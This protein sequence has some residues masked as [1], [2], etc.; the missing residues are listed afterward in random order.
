MKKIEKQLN[1]TLKTG[2]AYLSAIIEPMKEK[3][4]K[5]WSKMK[6]FAALNLV[7]DPCFKL[8]L[9]EFT[10]MDELTPSEA[11]AT[12]EQIKSSVIQCFIKLNSCQNDEAN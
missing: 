3:Y 7:F 9:I 10:L 2:P 4:D 1:N 8:E 6:D 11:A 5:Y 12:F